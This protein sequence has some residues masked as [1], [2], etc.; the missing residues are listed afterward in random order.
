MSSNPEK[1][2]PST[3]S[4]SSTSSS[5]LENQKKKEQVPP[6]CQID[7]KKYQNYTEEIRNKN[8]NTTEMLSASV[9]NCIHPEDSI[10]YNPKNIHLLPTKYPVYPL[11]LKPDTIKKFN[12]DT[13]FFIFFIQQEPITREMASRQLQERGWMFHQEYSTFFQ[14]VGTPKNRTEELIEGKFKFIDHESDWSIRIKK[15][16]KFDLNFLEK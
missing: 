9:N 2:N 11:S 3:Q 1:Q 14:L 15:E 6:P 7:L 12:D 10:I 13:L 8:L 4:S 5:Q 16:F